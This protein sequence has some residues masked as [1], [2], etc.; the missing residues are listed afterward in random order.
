MRDGAHVKLIGYNPSSPGAYSVFDPE[1]LTSTARTFDDGLK[2]D[3][4]SNFAVLDADG[5]TYNGA[6][7]EAG[8]GR[9]RG[10]AGEGSARRLTD[11]RPTCSWDV[12]M[13]GG[14]RSRAFRP[15]PD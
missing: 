8:R 13:R 1:T 14:R 15:F 10:W 2:I 7:V 3:Y 11:G 9:R 12:C 4:A 6:R 5:V